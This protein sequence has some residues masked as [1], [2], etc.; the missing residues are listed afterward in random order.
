MSV[1]IK[2]NGRIDLSQHLPTCKKIETLSVKSIKQKISYWKAVSRQR[3]QLA[4]LDDHLLADIGLSKEQVES[5]VS[6]PFWR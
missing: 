4:Q 1:L 5:E 2:N 6:K 3:R